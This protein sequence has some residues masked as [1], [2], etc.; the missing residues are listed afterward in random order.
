MT[1]NNKKKVQVDLTGLDEAGADSFLT[2]LNTLLVTHGLTRVDDEPP[3]SEYAGDAGIYRDDSS[4]RNKFLVAC[5]HNCNKAWG[6]SLR[7]QEEGEFH[8]DAELGTADADPGTRVRGQAK[9]VHLF[10][11]LNFWCRREC[12]RFVEVSYWVDGIPPQF[13]DFSTRPPVRT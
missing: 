11:A 4:S 7:V 1:T 5:D 8:S 10:E 12:E 2:S 13:P 6:K 3:Y 9:P